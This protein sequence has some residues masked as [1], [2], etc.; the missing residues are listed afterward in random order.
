MAKVVENRRMGDGIF[1]LSVQYKGVCK[2]G[3]FFMLRA[4]EDTPLLSRPI[5]IFDYK[6]HVV[7]FLLQVVGKGTKILSKLKSGDEI[8]LLGPYGNGFPYLQEKEIIIIG[9][10][11]GT[12]PLYYCARE[13]YSRNP[14]RMIHIYLGFRTEN[15]IIDLFRNAFP[16]VNIDV[17]GIITDHVDLDE[18]SVIFTCGP[19]RMMKKVCDI[20]KQKNK[21][22]Y[23]SIERKMA[24]GVGACLGC[25]CNTRN[26]NKRVC[27]DGPV[28]LGEDIIYE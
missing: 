6:D 12:A 19:E 5:S 8:T 7:V 13:L 24:C 18:G 3:Q 9:G 21:K 22:V 11:I 25:T 2:M 26:G 17:G 23:A 16:H 14:K 4:W 28:F 20:S 27:K 1:A 10:G 15:K